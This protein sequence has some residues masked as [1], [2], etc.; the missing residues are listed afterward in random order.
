MDDPRAGKTLPF[1]VA[2][3]QILAAFRD[4]HSKAIVLSGSSLRR[5]P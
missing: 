2:Q 1:R 4:L 3:A 5:T